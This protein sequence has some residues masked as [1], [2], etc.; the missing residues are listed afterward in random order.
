MVSSVSVQPELYL[1]VAG[2]VAAA[3]ALIGQPMRKAGI[4]PASLL[5]HKGMP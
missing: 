1:K 5:L 2:Y 3:A 4:I